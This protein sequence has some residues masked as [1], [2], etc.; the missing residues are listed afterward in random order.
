MINVTISGIEEAKR[1]LEKEIKKLTSDKTVLVGIHE[2]AGLTD[3]GDLTMAQLG[4]VLHFG[5][6][7]IPAR[8]WLDVGVKSGTQD[9]LEVIQNHSDDIDNALEIIGQIAVGKVQ[10]Y[11]T[12][13]QDPPNAPSTIAKKGSSNPLIDTGA[14]RQSVTYSITNTKP[15]EGLG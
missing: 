8:P 9:Y 5:T 10:Q 3:D 12:D 1:Q 6:Q 13:L 4:A 7:T 15:K 11:M 2:D 14:L